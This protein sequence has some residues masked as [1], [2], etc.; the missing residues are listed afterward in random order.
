MKLPAF[1]EAPTTTARPPLDFCG[2][3]IL[4]KDVSN[5]LQSCSLIS[6]GHSTIADEAHLPTPS[7]VLDM[8]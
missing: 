6:D 7:Y 8:S 1:E 5:C 3:I 2:V 4:G